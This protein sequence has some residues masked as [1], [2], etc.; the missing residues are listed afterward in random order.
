MKQ[1]KRPK[2]ERDARRSKALSVQNR[3]YRILLMRFL[4]H[5]NSAAHFCDGIMEDREDAADILGLPDPPNASPSSNQRDRWEALVK[6]SLKRQMAFASEVDAPPNA[7][8]RQAVVDQLRRCLT[9]L[10]PETPE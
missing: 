1:P 8:Q 3:H 2:S 10:D 7:A 9:A 6:Q 5:T 4:V